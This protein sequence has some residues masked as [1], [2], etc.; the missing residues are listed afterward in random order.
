MISK[1]LGNFKKVPIF[2]IASIDIYDEAFA[3]ALLQVERDMLSY[4][5]AELLLQQG[6]RTAL[7][8]EQIRLNL[9]RSEIHAFRAAAELF[10]AL[11]EYTALFLNR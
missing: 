9:R 3:A 5:E 11:G 6:G 2:E 10:T 4:R 8:V 1:G 7:E